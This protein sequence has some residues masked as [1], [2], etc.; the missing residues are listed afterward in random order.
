M[1]ASSV[2]PACRSQ[3]ATKV[4]LCAW[5]GNCMPYTRAPCGISIMADDR[6]ADACANLT[7]R[8]IFDQRET[9]V[10]VIVLV[11]SGMVVGTLVAATLEDVGLVEAVAPEV[12]SGPVVRTEPSLLKQSLG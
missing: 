5:I 12:V 6:S 11:A 2:G 4:V 7:P 8:Q 9:V 10:A 3:S 1:R